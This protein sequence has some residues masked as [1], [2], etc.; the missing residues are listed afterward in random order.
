M[1]EDGLITVDDR[2]FGDD[3]YWLRVIVANAT[4][5]PGTFRRAQLEE[6]MVYI[7][8]RKEFYNLEW[9]GLS[10]FRAGYADFEIEARKTKVKRQLENLMMYQIAIA[11]LLG[12]VRAADNKTTA[13]M[14]FK[15]RNERAKA[16]TRVAA[17]RTDDAAVAPQKTAWMQLVSKVH[18]ERKTANPGAKYSDS[19][20]KASDIYRGRA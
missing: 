11:R 3:L 10:G 20:K 1:L 12:S 9:V 14:S 2:R 8:K 16:T 13:I 17:L 5:F 6:L 7:K 18:A 15:Q 4:K 19:L